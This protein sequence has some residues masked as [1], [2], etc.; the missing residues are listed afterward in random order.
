MDYVSEEA[1]IAGKSASAYVKNGAKKKNV[2]SV[3]DV[4]KGNG[5]RYTVPQKIEVTDNNAD[6]KVYFRVGKVFTDVI[7]KAYIGDEIVA[8][9]KKRKMAPGEMEFITVKKSILDKNPCGKL[10]I[11]I[12][13]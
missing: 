1:D 8:N 13:E 4:E 2:I 11:E 12:M 6:V 3:I 7:L 10:K 5:V 9:S